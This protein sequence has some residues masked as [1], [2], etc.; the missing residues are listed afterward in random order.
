MIS[1]LVALEN[2]ELI[3]DIVE[4]DIESITVNQIPK[5]VCDL[6]W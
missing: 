5:G 4:G 2:I 6:E 3:K 1:S